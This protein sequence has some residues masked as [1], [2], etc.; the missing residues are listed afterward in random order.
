MPYRCITGICSDPLQETGACTKVLGNDDP[1]DETQRLSC[2]SGTC[3]KQTYRLPGDSCGF[4][5]DGQFI[6]CGG[7]ARCVDGKCAARAADG[8][9]C[10]NNDDCMKPSWCFGKCELPPVDQ[11]K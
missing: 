11:C 10:V 6:G 9:A 8:V 5:T 4:G 3:Q 1:C 7:G 2:Q